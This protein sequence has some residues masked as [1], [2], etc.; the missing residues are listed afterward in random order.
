MSEKLTLS[1]TL[2][3]QDKRVGAEKRNISSLVCPN[4]VRT[5]L[6]DL[7]SNHAIL[8]HWV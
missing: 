5:D 8:K 4:D 3:L 6:G 2:T 1:I 7:F